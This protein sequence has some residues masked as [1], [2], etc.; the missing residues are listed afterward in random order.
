LVFCLD[1]RR[2]ISQ[3][4]KDL[5]L[6][7]QEDKRRILFVCSGNTCRS[8]L[9]K[10]ILEQKLRARE[11]LDS[12]Q[13]DSAACDDP[14]HQWASTN[15]RRAVR[16]LFGDDLLASHE[17][18]RLTPDLVEQANLVLVMEARM[19]TGLPTEKTY[20]LKEYAGRP[21]DVAD[22][23]GDSLEGYLDCAREIS[24]ALEDIL[25]KLG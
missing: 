7:T 24:S 20:T 19:K 14:T 18:K 16:M 13:I 21:G 12:F 22:P 5:D 17:A 23:F 3:S 4:L 25:P 8:P 2:I 11:R 9:A 10:V 1:G 15:A 6:N